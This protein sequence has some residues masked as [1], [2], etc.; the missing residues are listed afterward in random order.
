VRGPEAAIYQRA[1]VTMGLY[2]LTKHRV[3][4]EIAHQPLADQVVMI[5]WRPSASRRS[6]QLYQSSYAAQILVKTLLFNNTSVDSRC[7][8]RGGQAVPGNVPSFRLLANLTADFTHCYSG[9]NQIQKPCHRHWD[10]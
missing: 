1:A 2:L 4:Q 8:F 5:A 7:L 6:W 9:G 3:L 10:S